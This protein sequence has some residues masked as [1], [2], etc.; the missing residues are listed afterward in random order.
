MI[1]KI[2]T[3][4]SMKIQSRKPIY[5][6][7]CQWLHREEDKTQKDVQNTSKYFFVRQVKLQCLFKTWRFANKH[8]LQALKCTH[9]GT[10]QHTWTH[11]M[12]S[13]VI[14]KPLT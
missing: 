4:V 11:I 7:L 10:F 13:I 2:N 1:M 8:N 5:I 6:S 9:A 14:F 3:N 12:F